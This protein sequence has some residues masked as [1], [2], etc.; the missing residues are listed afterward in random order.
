MN[1]DYLKKNR[2]REIS[3]TFLGTAASC[4]IDKG[5]YQHA[6]ERGVLDLLNKNIKGQ[7]STRLLTPTLKH[8]I[9][10]K[11]AVVADIS[12]VSDQ[13]LLDTLYAKRQDLKELAL[14]PRDTDDVYSFLYAGDSAYNNI[15]VSE[16]I[17]RLGAFDHKTRKLIGIYYNHCGDLDKDQILFG[18]IPKE[19]ITKETFIPCFIQE[20]IDNQ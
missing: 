12:G 1:K 5:E 2:L 3:A 19:L 7:L 9:N 4:F 13:Y 10:H 18:A 8:L 11:L 6:Y 15:L 20:I 16:H 14:P 17:R